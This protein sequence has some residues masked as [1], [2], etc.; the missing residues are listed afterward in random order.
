MGSKQL[1]VKNWHLTKMD[2]EQKM[3][4]KKIK[5]KWHL[6]KRNRTEKMGSKQ[7]QVKN[8][9][10]TKMDWEQKMGN[11]KIKKNGTLE[12]GIGRTKSE[13]NRSRRKTGI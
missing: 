10:L 3:G 1:Q 11:K 6:R 8:W 7:L 4:N 13:A 9:H 5:K 2:W 12:K